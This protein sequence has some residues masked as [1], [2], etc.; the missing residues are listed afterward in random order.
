M[1]T[2]KTSIAIITG[3][4]ASIGA[5]VCCAGPLILL[6]LGVSGSWIANLTLLEPFKVYFFALIIIMFIYAGWQLYRPIESCKPDSVCAIPKIRKQRQIIYW[7][8]LVF[9]LIFATSTY[10]LV[11]L[12][13]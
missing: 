6:L 9:A 4:M 2:E 13:A 12:M 11:W 1:K 7:C 10:W 5:S 3:L 8:A